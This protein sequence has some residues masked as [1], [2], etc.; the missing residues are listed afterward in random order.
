MTSQQHTVFRLS[1]SGATLDGL[2]SS[3]EPL[4]PVDKQSVLVKI[5]AVALNYRDIA[6]VNGTYPFPVKDSV[7]PCSDMCGVVQEVGSLV[8]K[9]KKGDKVVGNF[10]QDALYGAAT[11]W[12]SG[13]GGPLDGV[14]REY[15][16]L[17]EFG[18]VKIPEG[19]NMT[20]A[21]AAS[22]VCT[23]VTTWNSLYGNIPL[24]PGQTVL[25][26][27][28]GGVSLTALQIAKAAGAKTIITSSSDEKLKLVQEHYHPTHIIN[29]K[30]KPDW[31]Q[32]VLR[33]TDGLGADYIIETGGIGTIEKSLACV[34]Y[35]GNISVIGFLGGSPRPEDRPDVAALALGKG[36]VVRGIMVGNK[37]QL[38]E[39][40]RFAVVNDLHMAVD[41]VFPFTD[42]GVR[43][44]YDYLLAAKHIGKVCI[45][46]EK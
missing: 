10:I 44:A 6:I 22:L 34:A 24:K 29:Y 43:E 42:S 18:V 38:E 2:K 9:F 21:E 31:D 20:D 17:P 25:L 39:M 7:V 11:N 32:E 46:M 33:L 5:N 35:G 12:N 45:S 8:T 3:K 26:M 4:P 19:S 28:T 16:V 15:V 40:V 14:L 13:L 1:L 30:T 23:G 41:T 27:G 36:A 37:Q